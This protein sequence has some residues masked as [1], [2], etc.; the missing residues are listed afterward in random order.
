M[1][2]NIFLLKLSNKNIM[3]KIILQLFFTTW[4]QSTSNIFKEYILPSNDTLENHL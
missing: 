2:L 4:L 3:L 1:R